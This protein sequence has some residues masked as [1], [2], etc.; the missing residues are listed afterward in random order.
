MLEEKAKGKTSSALK[1]LMGLQPNIVFKV[2]ENGILTEIPIKDVKPGDI[3]MVKPGEKIA[4]DGTL[5]AGNSFVDE[6]MITGEPIPTEKT[7]DSKVFAGTINQKGSFKFVAEKTGN[8]TLLA[9]I[10]KM[11]QEAQGSK[12]KVQRLVD[13]IAGIFVPV[14]ISIAMISF[15]IWMI[16]GSENSFSHGLIS[17]V[18]VL[19][20]ACPC[21]LGLA[22]PT[23]IMVGIGKGAENGILIKDADSLE[24]AVQLDTIV[25]D[26]TGTLTEGKPR[27]S[28]VFWNKDDESYKN[29]LVSIESRSEH[30]L[31]EAILNKLGSTTISIP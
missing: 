5:T 31:A 17:F 27:V 18:T 29:I 25:M 8:D 13:K 26:K 11:V 1:K 15:F 20:I 12:A 9:N 2:D 14:V 19:V 6:S 4:V 30:P 28:E 21:A 23:A 7:I 24:K 22:T 10:I 3:I 16:S